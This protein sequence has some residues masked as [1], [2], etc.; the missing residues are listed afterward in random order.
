MKFDLYQTQNFAPGTGE[1][2][3]HLSYSCKKS[4]N[5]TEAEPHIAESRE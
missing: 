1:K 3:T 4:N 5:K 2:K